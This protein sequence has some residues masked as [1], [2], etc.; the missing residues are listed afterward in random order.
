MNDSLPP[1]QGPDLDS[2]M[3]IVVLL[4]AMVI[5]GAAVAAIVQTYLQGRLI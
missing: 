2:V 4:T 5:A 3:K 1:E